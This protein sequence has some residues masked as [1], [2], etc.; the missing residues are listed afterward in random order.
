MDEVVDTV[1]KVFRWLKEERDAD[2]EWEFHGKEESSAQDWYKFELSGRH[3]WAAT[4]AHITAHRSTEHVGFHCT[5]ANMLVEILST[6]AL[7]EGSCH[8]D[9]SHTPYAVLC[10]DKLESATGGT[11]QKG[12]VVECRVY[13]MRT[14][15]NTAGKEQKQVRPAPA[16]SD[17]REEFL[18]EPGRIISWKGGVLCCKENAMEL[19]AIYLTKEAVGQLC[20][21]SFRRVHK[22]R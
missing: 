13:G 22:R 12:V 2:I 9:N 17:W 14:A 4:R 10:C 3:L 16:D 20:N 5:T 21:V 6:G 19:V 1:Q 11:Y 7:K 18:R 15:Y 8:K